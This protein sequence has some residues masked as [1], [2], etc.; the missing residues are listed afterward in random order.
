MT[1][2]ATPETERKQNTPMLIGLGFVGGIVLGALAVWGFAALDT[3]GVLT[4]G[5]QTNVNA[6]G[7]NQGARTSTSPGADAVS[8]SSPA[9]GPRGE[10]TLTIGDQGSGG[11]VFIGG[12]PTDFSGWVAVYEDENGSLGRALGATRFGPDRT[13]NIVP[14]L[15][16]TVPG[17]TYYGVIHRD[18]GDRMFSLGSDPHVRDVSGRLLFITFTTTE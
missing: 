14:L 5:T 9:L 18:D 10:S 6:P 11:Q 13:P 12:T 2:G 16:E 7:G 4:T 3:D 17:Q 8:V 1:N 15:R